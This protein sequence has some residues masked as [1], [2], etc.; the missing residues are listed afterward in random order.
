GRARGR[1]RGPGR[2]DRPQGPAPGPGPRRGPRP[3]RR[4]RRRD[5]RRARPLRR[6]R[7][8]RRGHGT[9][10]HGGRRPRPGAAGGRARG[11]R[12][13]QRPDA[14][15][16]HGP[17]PVVLHGRDVQGLHVRLR[18]TAP[19]RR[20]LR[21][22]AAAARRR[23][24]PGPRP[25]AGGRGGR[26]RA[27]RRRG[28]GALP[29][30]RRPARGLAGRPGRA[31][32]ARCRRAG[33]EVGGGRPRGRPRRGRDGRRRLP[34]A[35]ARH[36]GHRQRAPG[37][38]ARRDRPGGG[39]APALPAGG[40]GRVSGAAERTGQGAAERPWLVVALPKGRVLDAALEVLRR[41]GVAVEVP[42]DPRALRYEGDGVRALVMR[43]ADVPTYVDLGV[44]DAGV[45]GYDVLLE[46]GSRLYAP[47]DLGFG[48]CRVSLVR[49]RGA[50]GPV[51]RV[52]S[53][54]PRMTAEYLRRIGSPAEVVALSG[55][56][57]LACLSGLA[58]AV[59]D[60]VETGATLAA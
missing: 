23:L 17:A 9:R 7:G 36:R 26:P 53:K 16:R 57:E 34:A 21:R 15:P 12:G 20:P 4:R 48:R 2:R 5:R 35:A 59:V 10:A 29:P 22:R 52:A 39:P 3:E 11:V 44:A 18:P 25:R 41:V 56:V 28:Q 42:E 49:P 46:S 45:V 51:R 47:V 24:R 8:H 38:A 50:T 33:R 13:P 19:R 54:Y 58:D 31:G 43:N 40:G 1:P 27:A 55:N 30:R 37:G 14:G 32:P 6:A 60:V